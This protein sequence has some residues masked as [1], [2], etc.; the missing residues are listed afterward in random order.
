MLMNGMLNADLRV[1]R[2]PLPKEEGYYA[3]LY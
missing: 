1:N 2:C 3:N